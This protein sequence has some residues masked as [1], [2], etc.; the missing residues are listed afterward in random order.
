M[1]ESWGK[2]VWH[3]VT[4]MIVYEGITTIVELILSFVWA[5]RHIND[6]IVNNGLDEEKLS[7]G[8]TTFISHYAILLQGIGALVS[9]FFLYRMYV[10]DYSRRRFVFDRESVARK[11]LLLLIPVGVFSSLSGQFFLN[12]GSFAQ[13]SSSFQE[14]ETLIFSANAAAQVIFVGVVIPVA[15]EFVYRGLIYMRMRQYT[16]VNTAIIL[17]SLIFALMHGNPVQ[18]IYAFVLGVLFCYM[19]EKYGTLL[20]PVLLHVSA[21]LL[22]VAVYYISLHHDIPSST[23]FLAAGGTV[24]LAAA[25]VFI[26]LADRHVEA[27]R[28]YLDGSDTPQEKDMS[29]LSDSLRDR[30]DDGR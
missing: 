26:F 4:P 27:R 8:L 6:F 20:A 3:L 7:E 15:E 17:S 10:K 29:D 16:N 14:S 22:S 21:N 1:G 9:I 5:G 11:M 18:G 30:D 13:D 25:L 19:Y 28:I 2:R 23:A 24:S 12:I